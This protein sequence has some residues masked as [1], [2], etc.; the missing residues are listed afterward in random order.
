[1]T[2]EK[3]TV[4][5]KRF[6]AVTPY[7]SLKRAAGVVAFPLFIICFWLAGCAEFA[8]QRMNDPA[9]DGWQ[10]PSEVI[11][12]LGI[13]PGSR[14]ADLGAGGGYFTWYLASAVG[15]P[16]MVY[17]VDVDDTALSIIK[18]ASTA[19]RV[20]NVVPVRADSKDAK[21]PEPV[22]LVFS[23]DPFHHMQDRVAYFR[24]LK[25]Y[26]KPDARVAV[27]DFHPRGLFAGLLGHGTAKDEVRREMEEA[28]YRRVADY[29]LIESQHFQVFLWNDS[30]G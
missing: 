30:K 8:Y 24:A 25:R 27:L 4:V 22:D 19:R 9:R 7:R 15:A 26:L 17:A 1:M 21:L 6:Q 28:G 3:L 10:K 29:N 5:P 2:S 12:V 11:E 16:G 13:K 20:T 23:C 18:Q 14:V